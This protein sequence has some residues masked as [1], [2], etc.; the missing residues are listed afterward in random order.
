MGDATERLVGVVRRFGG[1]ATRD[2]WVFD[3]A[4][5]ELLFARPDVADSLDRELMDR[6]IDDERYGF[7]TRNTF[8]SLYDTGYAFTVRGFDGFDQYRT[9]VGA[10][11]E[12]N[13]VGV[14]A[15]F[16]ETRPDG[17][18]DYRALHEAVSALVDE[19]GVRAVAPATGT[20]RD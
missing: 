8:E 9:F 2:V 20:T 10:A 1:D 6:A 19:V 3:Q 4:T 13:D 15:R 11:D 5:H 18:I 16:D 7:V 17:E 12:R 14:L